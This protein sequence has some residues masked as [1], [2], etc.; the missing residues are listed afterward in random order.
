MY[1]EN[2]ADE[3]D[4]VASY[5]EIAPHIALFDAVRTKDAPPAPKL[6]ARG[7]GQTRRLRKTLHAAHPRLLRH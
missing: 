5:A 3:K 2:D 6:N 7:P 1:L 4:A